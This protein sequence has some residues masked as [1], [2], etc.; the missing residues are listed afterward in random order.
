[1][2][3]ARPGS[4]APV[5]VLFRQRHFVKL[6]RAG[7]EH[8]HDDAI[9]EAVLAACAF[10]EALDN[11]AVSDV[12]IVGTAALRTAGN[13][14]S[15]IRQLEAILGHSIRIIDGQQEAYLIA[16]GVRALLTEHPGLHLVLDIGGGSV[17][18]I[19]LDEGEIRSAVSLPIGVAV[20]HHQFHRQEP[21]PGDDLVAMRAYI[22]SRVS[23]WLSPYRG[24]AIRSLIGASGIF[25]VLADFDRQTDDLLCQIPLNRIRDL[26]RQ[27]TAIDLHARKNIQALPEERADLIVSAM[28]LIEVM[29]EL[30]RPEKIYASAYAMK[31]GVLLYRM[32]GGGY[33]SSVNSSPEVR[34]I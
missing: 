9:D 22:S 17:E 18:C 4:H 15:F 8:I 7:I 23:P 19:L 13:A 16:T 5:D 26:T 28:N 29:I 11:Y 2:L 21:I 32:H 33:S 1:M 20:L 27:V 34:P 12:S 14:A 3:I 30:V 10:R 24:A 6:A 25:D 31:E